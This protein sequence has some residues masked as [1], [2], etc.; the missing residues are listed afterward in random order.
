MIFK[1]SKI[2]DLLKGLALTIGPWVVFLTALINI[3]DIP[4]GTQITATLAAVE[5]FIGALVTASK[6]AYSKQGTNNK[7]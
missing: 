5:A 1:D 4:Y 2:Y 3:W 7:L 6:H